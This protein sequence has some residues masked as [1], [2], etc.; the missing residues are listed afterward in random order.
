MKRI[1]VFL[2]T[3]VMV[4]NLASPL[5]AMAAQQWGDNTGR[6]HVNNLNDNGGYWNTSVTVSGIT[7]TGTPEADSGTGM[8]FAPKKLSSTL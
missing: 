7:G 4:G 1:H 6:T 8:L 2:A 5:T 3:L